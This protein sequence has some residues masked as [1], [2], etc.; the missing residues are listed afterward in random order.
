MLPKWKSILRRSRVAAHVE[1][2]VIIKFKK[3]KKK[4]KKKAT[5]PTRNPLTL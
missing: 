5:E 4:T 3:A 1:G 2:A